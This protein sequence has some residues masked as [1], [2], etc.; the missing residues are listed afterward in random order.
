[1]DAMM[2]EGLADEVRRLYPYRELNALNTVGYK[3]LFDYFENMCTLDEAVQKIKDHTRQY[4]RRQLTWFRKQKDTKW[5]LP[6]EDE[7]ILKFV[8]ETIVRN[9]HP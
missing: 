7:L 5:F 1:V 8:H 9:E 3:E 2:A 6:N 4:A